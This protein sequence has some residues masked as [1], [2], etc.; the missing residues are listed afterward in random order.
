MYFSELM[1]EGEEV[2][3]SYTWEEPTN[4]TLQSMYFSK[5]MAEGEEVPLLY[6][7]PFTISAVCSDTDVRSSKHR[8][9][10]IATAYAFLYVRSLHSPICIVYNHGYFFCFS[11]VMILN[12]MSSAT[13]RY[14]VL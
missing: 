12:N 10:S 7:G 2:Q 11:F 8:N 14:P 3:L 9:V 1:D 4:P 6:H 13:S 5:M